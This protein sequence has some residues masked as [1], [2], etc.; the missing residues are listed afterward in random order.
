MHDIM[1]DPKP[2]KLP[3]RLRNDSWLTA[4]LYRLLRDEVPFGA[5][6]KILADM[7]KSGADAFQLNEQNIAAYAREIAEKL[8]P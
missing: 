6:E 8:Q 3:P 1:Y 2:I 4:F 7:E 5:V